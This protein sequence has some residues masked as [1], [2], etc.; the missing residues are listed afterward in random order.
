MRSIS[1]STGTMCRAGWTFSRELQR[2]PRRDLRFA[3][4]SKRRYLPGQ[5]I[6]VTGVP[7]GDYVLETIVDPDD[8]ILESDDDNDKNN[9]GSVLI[10]LSHM[11]TPQRHAEITGP[12]PA[13]KN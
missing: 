1:S 5:Y 2:H 10:R 8:K 7:D 13:C 9:C 12:G 3:V 6:E 4:A 11:G